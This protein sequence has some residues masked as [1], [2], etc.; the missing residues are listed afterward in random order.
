[1]SVG[2]QHHVPAALP[3][4]KDPLPIVQHWAQDR[5]GLVGIISPPLG[6]DPQAFQPLASRYTD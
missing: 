3:A 2:G 4:G 5:S 6:V 1:M